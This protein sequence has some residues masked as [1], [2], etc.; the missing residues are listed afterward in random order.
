L[1]T[2]IAI[3]NEEFRRA[4][5][6]PNTGQINELIVFF[7]NNS[8]LRSSMVKETIISDGDTL[9]LLPIHGGG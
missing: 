5:F 1:L 7:L 6:D 8:Y 9:M 2:K 4:V 3:N